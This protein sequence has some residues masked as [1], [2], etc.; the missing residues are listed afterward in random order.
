MSIIKELK[1]ILLFVLS[2][3]K[4]AKVP[5]KTVL[6]VV[7]SIFIYLAFWN[8][9]YAATVT[10]EHRAKEIDQRLKQEILEDIRNQ[11]IQATEKIRKSRKFEED[12]ESEQKELT[13]QDKDKCIPLDNIY[14]NGNTVYSSNKFRRKFLRTFPK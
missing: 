9:L 4:T 2:W 13:S 14:F 6:I 3:K 10:Q 11:E 8:T 1:N 12:K 7:V 5:L